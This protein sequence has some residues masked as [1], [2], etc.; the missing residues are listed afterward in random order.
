MKQAEHEQAST[1]KMIM[2]KPTD[3]WLPGPSGSVWGMGVVV[4]QAMISD[5]DLDRR[6]GEN[7][8]LP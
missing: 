2:D 6:D 3:V 8:V 7:D 5:L 1:S 4:P